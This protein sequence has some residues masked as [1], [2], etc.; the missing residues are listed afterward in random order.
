MQ[1]A[2]LRADVAFSAACGLSFVILSAGL[3]DWADLPTW[4]VVLVG[5]LILGHVG[6][7]LV[8][9]R[10]PEYEAQVTRY[11]VVANLGWVVAAAVVVVSGWLPEAPAGL[12][13]LLS[14]VVGVFGLLQLWTL[15]PGAVRPPT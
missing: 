13:V 1:R 12:F 14:A 15:R 7:L 11:A 5:I 3:A 4:V 10:R 6:I 2:L 9:V 8:G